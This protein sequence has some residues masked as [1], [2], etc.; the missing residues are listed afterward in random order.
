[1]SVEEAKQAGTGWENVD[2]TVPAT[3]SSGVCCAETVCRIDV[4]KCERNVNESMSMSLAKK[5]A[6]KAAV[7]RH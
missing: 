2:A 7:G 1:M 4:I 6:F 3:T 5:A